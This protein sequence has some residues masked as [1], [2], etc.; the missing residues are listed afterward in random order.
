[1][2]HKKIKFGQAQETSKI[3]FRRKNTPCND[4]KSVKIAILGE[5]QIHG[6]DDAFAMR[7]Y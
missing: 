3:E 2:M 6:D 5:R 7:P 4:L 1:M